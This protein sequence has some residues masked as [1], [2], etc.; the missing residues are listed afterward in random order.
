MT[1]FDQK[2]NPSPFRSLI[3]LRIVEWELARCLVELDVRPD[4]TNFSGALAG[5]I[6][7]AMVDMAGNLAGCYSTELTTSIKAVTITFD[8]AF[9]D[10]V[11]DGTVSALAVKHGSGR[12]IYYST[13]RVFTANNQTI[14]LGKGTFRYVR[15]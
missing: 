3:G 15:A 1:Q 5:P 6:I 12:S 8:V 11:R 2:A 14:A 4:L 13:V 10:S 7:G 9:V